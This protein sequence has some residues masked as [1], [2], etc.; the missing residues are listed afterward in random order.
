ML[1]IILLM[2]LLSTS[3]FM[4]AQHV[5]KGV[6]V[7]EDK[8]GDFS[9]LV[10][11]NIYWL[12]T[13]EGTTSDENGVFEINCSHEDHL[14]VISYV[15]YS[16]DTV[17]IEKHDELTIVLKNAK[18]LYGV[19]ITYR[20]K[21]TEISFIDPIKTQ[22]ISQDE[23]FKAACCNLAESFE[24]NP[25]VD[26]SFT[27]AVTGTRQI[28]M[29]GLA[30]SY[31]QISQGNMPLVRGLAVNAGLT[32][33]PGTWISSLQLMKGTGSVVNGFESVAG[34][35]NVEIKNSYDEELFFLN[36]YGN[37][38]GRMEL[39]TNFTQEIGAKWAATTLLH[40][41]VKPFEQ[42]GNDDGFIDFPIG[43]GVNALQRWQYTNPTKGIESQFGFR[44]L[45][46]D[47]QGG[48]SDFDPDEDKF[49]SNAYGVGIKTQRFE[50]WGK[51]GY[52]F[53]EKRYK[54]IGFTALG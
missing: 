4:H 37:Q 39:N 20:K 33:V 51:L 53:P 45:R 42:D 35:I 36:L 17:Q 44:Y 50:G 1:R 18:E 11:V 34:Q 52:V 49:T 2:L 9:P 12:G 13:T 10:G 54:S 7:E 27:D 26:V 29:L 30:G 32:Y 24:T 14:L 23:L 41:N 8:K 21:S 22:I 46:K 28:T 19:E 38:E 3:H 47:Q 25:S 31:T 16:S 6:V 43:Y 15:G 48:Q 40:A 5:L